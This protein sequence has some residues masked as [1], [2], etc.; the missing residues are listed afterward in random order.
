M[1]NLCP[2]LGI[3]IDQDLRY[4][5]PN[6]VNVCYADL[7]GWSTFRP[8]ELPHQR[9][10]CLT[11]EHRLC[12]VF[13]RHMAGVTQSRPRGR[14]Q[15]YLQFFG[16]QEEPFSIVPQPRF[17]VESQDQLQAH[18]SLRW[19]IDQRQGLGLLLGPV[20]TGKTLLCRTLSEELSSE[21]QYITALL[22]TPSH[23]SEYA[24]MADLLTSWKVKPARQ[25]SL[26]DLEASTHRFLVQEVLDRQRTV[27]LIVDEAQTLS[28][29]A[30]EQ[31]CKLLNWQDGGEQLLQVILA[32]QPRLQA[33]LNRVPALRDRAIVDFALTAMTLPDAQRMVSERL[34]RAGRRG[35]LFAPSALQAI[36]QRAGGMPRQITILC[37]LCLWFAYQ[38]GVR[39]ISAD[40]AQAVIDHASDRDLFST[41]GETAVEIATSWSRPAGKLS[42]AWLPRLFQWLTARLTP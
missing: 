10:F 20:G 29:R 42:G 14:S 34:Q 41:P 4:G 3:P 19:L 35:D 11:P 37:Q 33:K 40:V 17:L 38:K 26:R 6:P 12:P 21:P 9:Q 25:R 1:D 5:Y 23:Y 8:V 32:A 22:L 24:L 30:L 36:Y 2:H 7:A 15:S 13:L 18:T 39:H 31:V 16:L 27:V 28:R